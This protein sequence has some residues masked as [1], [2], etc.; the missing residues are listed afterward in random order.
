MV[1]QRVYLLWIGLKG[2]EKILWLFF[3]DHI[4]IQS[5]CC[6]ICSEKCY[7]NKLMIGKV[8]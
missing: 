3:I 2:F 1:V 8:D 6:D 4:T 5:I 7:R